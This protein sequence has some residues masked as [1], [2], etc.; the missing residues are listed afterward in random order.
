MNRAAVFDRDGT[1]IQDA[2]YLSDPEGVI[3]LEGVKTTLNLLKKAKFR[4]AMVSNQSGIGRGMFNE[5]DCIEVNQRLEELLELKFDAIE[6]CPHRPGEGCRC[7]KP[8]PYLIQKVLDDL[9]CDTRMSFFAGDKRS[10]IEAGNDA[11]VRTIWC[12]FDPD[13][14]EDASD[15]AAATVTEFSQILSRWNAVTDFGS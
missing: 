6:Y 5:S 8:S 10:D 7:R 14:T 2:G 11:G 3:L 12:N 13:S 9:E 1:L 15:I 4:L